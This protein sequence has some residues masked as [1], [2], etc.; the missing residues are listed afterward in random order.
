[1][2]TAVSAESYVKSQ[3]NLSSIKIKFTINLREKAI[4]FLVFDKSSAGNF[5]KVTEIKLTNRLVCSSRMAS[6]KN[7]IQLVFL[8]YNR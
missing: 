4:D 3:S 2:P 8:A 1:M 7:C 5:V 6:E